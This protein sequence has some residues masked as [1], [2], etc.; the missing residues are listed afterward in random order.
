MILNSIQSSSSFVMASFTA[1]DEEKEQLAKF[2]DVPIEEM[3]GCWLCTGQFVDD[4]NMMDC[5]QVYTEVW[6]SNCDMV[7]ADF[8]EDCIKELHDLMN[9]LVQLGSDDKRKEKLGKSIKMEVAA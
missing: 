7:F 3:K 8:K 4:T 9:D 6:D 5:I 2:L 1:T